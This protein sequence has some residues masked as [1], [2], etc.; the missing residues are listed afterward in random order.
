MKINRAIKLAFKNLNKAKTKTTLACIGVA[1]GSALLII[2]VSAGFGLKK[3]ANDDILAHFKSLEFITVLPFEAE[4]GLGADLSDETGAKFNGTDI[5]NIKNAAGSDSKVYTDLM[6]FAST[7]DFSKKIPVSGG[8]DEYYQQEFINQDKLSFTGSK[9]LKENQITLSDN[10]AE[11]LGVKVG[12]KIELLFSFPEQTADYVYAEDVP[13]IEYLSGRQ[14]V[15]EVVNIYQND[16]NVENLMSESFISTSTSQKVLEDYQEIKDIYNLVYVK[17][18]SIDKV[19][20]VSAQIDE[21]GYYNFTYNKIIE[22]FNEAYKTITYSVIAVGIAALLIS[23]FGI[24]NTMV[25]TVMERT[26]EIGLFKAL[27]MT[28]K[29]IKTIFLCEAGLIGFIGSLVGIIGSVLFCLLGNHLLLKYGGEEM[30][31]AIFDIRIWLLICVFIFSILV[32]IIS[33]LIPASK[34]AKIDPIK[35]LRSY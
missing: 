14:I 1:I 2:L 4:I 31:F 12:D 27:G 18:S 16:E 9:E 32:S 29:N 19:D 35:A 13:T 20:E 26:R 23:M 10:T 15:M 17:A 11:L 21:A 30:S 25:M 28:N 24:A 7:S 5:N 6:L 8:S 22:G 33:G 3:T 34:A